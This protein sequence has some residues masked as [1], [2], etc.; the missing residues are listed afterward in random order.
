MSSIRTRHLTA[1]SCLSVSSTPCTQDA[2]IRRSVAEEEYGLAALCYTRCRGC[3]VWVLGPQLCFK[4]FMVSTRL[5]VA[6]VHGSSLTRSTGL[7]NQL[8]SARELPK[9]FRSQNGRQSYGAVTA[10][11]EGGNEL[12]GNSAHREFHDTGSGG[13]DE[14]DEFKVAEHF[15]LPASRL[16]C[17]P[18]RNLTDEVRAVLL[19]SAVL[20]V[21]L[22]M[23]ETFAFQFALVISWPICQSHPITQSVTQSVTTLPLPVGHQPLFIRHRN[24][25]HLEGKRVTS[26]STSWT[27][28]AS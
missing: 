26:G 21:Q 2:P 7:V 5:Q 14:V 6:D 23:L 12:H 17:L 11:P 10:A 27:L 8:A 4:I 18:Y 3:R 25:E 9:V 24:P 28:S 16:G 19:A 1:S 13:V 20:S 22:T 15:K